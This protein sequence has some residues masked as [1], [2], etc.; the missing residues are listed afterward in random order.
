[1]SVFGFKGNEAIGS[2]ILLEFRP[3][4]VKC[5]EDDPG[6]IHGYRTGAGPTAPVGY[7]RQ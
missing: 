7:H 6:L 5:C 2:F 1:M 3:G 4:Y